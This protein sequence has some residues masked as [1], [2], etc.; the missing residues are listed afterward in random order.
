MKKFKKVV[1]WKWNLSEFII[2][3]FLAFILFP[4]TFLVLYIQNIQS[5]LKQRKVYYVEIKSPKKTNRGKQNENTS[6]KNNR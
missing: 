6:C 4:V 1:K 3:Y 2:A 5:H